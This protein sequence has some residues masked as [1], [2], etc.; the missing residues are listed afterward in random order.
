MP[1]DDRKLF[2]VLK[3]EL[4][5]LKRGGYRNL[6]SMSWRSPLL[7]HDS[8]MCLNFDRARN[9]RPCHACVMTSLVTAN[10][11]GERFPCRHIP[12]NEAGFTSIPTIV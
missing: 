4:A 3:A 9:P 10:C 1:S 8:P 11:L 6:P 5:Y 2:S 7:L 12:L